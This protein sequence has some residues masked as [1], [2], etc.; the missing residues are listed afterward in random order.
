MN[1]DKLWDAFQTDPELRQTFRAVP[2]LRRLL[3]EIRTHERVLNIGVGDG[4]FERLA[5]VRGLAVSSLDPSEGTIRR[6]RE[7]YGLGQNA[8]VG[9]VA[10]IPFPPE[11]FDVVV[12]SEVME[13]LDD[14]TL[15][16]ALEQVARVLKPNGQL[17]GTVPAEEDLRAGLTV[18]PGC[19]TRFHRWGHLQSFT[20]ESLRKR[21]TTHFEILDVR[22][23]WFPDYADLNWKGRVLALLKLSLIRVG[24]TGEGETL[25]VKARRR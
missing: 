2:R 18:C 14:A 9:S 12:M 20:P 11:S 19:G 3:A 21:L 13:H 8:Q 1:Q 25:F 16:A 4:A 10:D 5:L 6:L 23:C 22:R 7:A 24:V 15:D 17:L